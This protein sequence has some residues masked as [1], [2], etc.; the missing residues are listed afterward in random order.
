[1]FPYMFY[2]DFTALEVTLI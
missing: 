1:M 2:A